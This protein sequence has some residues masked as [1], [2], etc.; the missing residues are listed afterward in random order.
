MPLQ[1]DIR[2]TV[3]STHLP[4]L[5]K[6]L[7]AA[8]RLVPSRLQYL[9]VAVVGDTRMA[10]LHQ[11]FLNIKGPTDVL[12]FELDHDPRRRVTS[13]EVVVC[14]PYAARTARSLGTSLRNELLLYCVHGLLH[15]TGYDDLDDASFIKMHRKEDEILTRLGIGPVFNHASTRKTPPR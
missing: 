15:L 8:A 2:S 3:R 1:I 12:T 13:G 14:Q 6:H 4:F 5:Q 10:R 11:R 9:S 7:A